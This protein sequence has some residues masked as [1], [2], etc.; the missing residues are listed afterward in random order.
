ML[1]VMEIEKVRPQE[2]PHRLTDGNGLH[3]LVNPNGSKL[4]RFR[5]RFG[6]KQNL[7][8]LGS[9]PDVGLATA[10]QKRDDARQLIGQ[11]IDP[12]QK[13]KDE[14]QA[15][16]VAGQN[17]FKVTAEE[18]LAKLKEEGKADATLDKNMWLLLDLASP[19]ADRPITDSPIG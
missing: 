18:Y 1:T 16:V 13:R 9:F 19:L 7:L 15:L 11:G 12:S 6:G 3:L 8:S 4:W 17:T 10:R 14:R 5:Y 2:K